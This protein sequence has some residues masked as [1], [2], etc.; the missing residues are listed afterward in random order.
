VDYL[1]KP[2]SRGEILNVLARNIHNPKCSALVVDDDP[3]SRNLISTLLQEEGFSVT[4]AENGLEALEKVNEFKPSIIVID[5]L[6]PV[7]D[8][9]TFL[10][11]LHE[12]RRMPHF[13]TIVVTAKDLS[14]SESCYIET[15]ANAVLQ[16][17]TTLSEDLKQTVR[18]VL[19]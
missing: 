2:I 18:T 3:D 5:L 7:M 10:E 4:T 6:M 14:F 13:P 9:I 19:N 11:K 17:G 16:K 12:D 8:G 1:N 15:H